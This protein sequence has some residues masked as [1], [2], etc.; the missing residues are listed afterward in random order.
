MTDTDPQNSAPDG[1]RPAPPVRKR[2]PQAEARRVA[3]PF[4]VVITAFLACCMLTG[5]L[6]DKSKA[7]SRDSTFELVLSI[8]TYIGFLAAIVWGVWCAFRGK[9]REWRESRARSEAA[10]GRLA[11]LLQGVGLPAARGRAVSSSASA[12]HQGPY[13]LPHPAGGRHGR[14]VRGAQAP[15]Q[16]SQR[17]AIAACD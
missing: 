14:L 9:G 5:L 15:S 4:A 10:R 13:S 12:E 2:S 16:G 1:E 11:D 6:T 7:P 3:I 17:Q 8:I